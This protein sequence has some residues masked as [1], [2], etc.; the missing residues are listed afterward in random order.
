MHSNLRTPTTS[1]VLPRQK[2]SAIRRAPLDVTSPNYVSRRLLVGTPTT[3]YFSADDVPMQLEEEV[4]N[5]NINVREE[6]NFEEEPSCEREQLPATLHEC[7]VRGS[8][9]MRKA[10]K[11]IA[12]QKKRGVFNQAAYKE[13]V[14]SEVATRV[15]D[16]NFDGLDETDEAATCLNLIANRLQCEITLAKMEKQNRSSEIADK[17]EPSQMAAIDIVRTVMQWQPRVKDTTYQKL[18][19]LYRYIFMRIT[20]PPQCIRNFALR[21]NGRGGRNVSL[22][23]LPLEIENFLLDF[24]EDILGY[25]HEEIIA[26]VKLNLED[27]SFYNSLGRN[28]AE[29]TKTLDILAKERL[30]WRT[31][32]FRS[33]QK[34][35]R[36]IRAYGY[37]QEEGTWIPSNRQSKRMAED[38]VDDHDLFEEEE[39]R[40]PSSLFVQ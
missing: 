11:L 35:L 20:N 1:R 32:L 4:S 24:G 16:M 25:G 34:A 18:T 40:R 31:H 27:P 14:N 36:D 28:E 17:G 12:E 37:N 3:D 22:K 6:H 9:Q 21:V 8:L 2:I 38:P 15:K 33:L 23:S 13:F 10:A 30:K 39:N 29:R 7:I 5:G 19:S 26:G